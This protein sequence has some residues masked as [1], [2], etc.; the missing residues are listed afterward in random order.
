MKKII[1]SCAVLTIIAGCKTLS[2]SSKTDYCYVDKLKLSAAGST[3]FIEL[4]NESEYPDIQAETTDIL[5]HSILKKQLFTLNLV[6]QDSPAWKSIGYQPNSNFTLEQLYQLQQSLST[7]AVLVGSVIDFQPYPHLS[8]AMRLKMTDLADGQ[9]IWAAE[10]VWDSA[11]KNI[12][13]RV[14]KYIRANMRTDRTADREKLTF[15]SSKE[16]IK[17]VCYELAETMKNQ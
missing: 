5:Y 3:A 17:F 1:L 7:R 2:T 9:T 15:V 12:E 4:Y 6:K 11:D 8:I 10:Q 13:Q 14:E 16:F